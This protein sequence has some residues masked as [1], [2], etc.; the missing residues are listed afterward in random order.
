MSRCTFNIC[1]IPHSRNPR[2][3]KARVRHHRSR[4]QFNI[5]M[6]RFPDNFLWGVSTSAHQVEGGNTHN[7]WAAWENTGHI[8]D[9]SRSG[10]AC[11]F[12]DH[13]ELDLQLMQELGVNSARISVE[14]SRLEPREGWWRKEI[15][16]R[17]G[18]LLR[19]MAS[20]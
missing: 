5:R 19:E 6:Y 16:T 10:R 4:K 20:R 14:W 1:V 2:T 8:R 15:L 12:W 9:G 11:D 7:Q 3:W 13:P 18:A 17:Y